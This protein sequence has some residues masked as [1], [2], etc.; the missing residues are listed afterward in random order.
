MGVSNSGLRRDKAHFGPALDK[1]ILTI[2]VV[3]NGMP[4]TLR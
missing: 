1:P 3:L 2:V 4:G